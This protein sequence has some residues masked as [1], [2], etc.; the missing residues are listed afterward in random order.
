MWAVVHSSKVPSI[1]TLT[2][3]LRATRTAA[4]LLESSVFP[5]TLAILAQAISRQAVF[6]AR[7]PLFKLP[8][9]IVAS[10]V[11]CGLWWLCSIYSLWLWF[12][13]LLGPLRKLALPVELRTDG[14]CE[15]DVV[16]DSREPHAVGLAASRFGKLHRRAKGKETFHS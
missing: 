1:V 2:R 4:C 12:G 9:V 11:V 3:V 14:M 13:S 8:H 6:V 10:F 7:A 16:R 15:M 5:S